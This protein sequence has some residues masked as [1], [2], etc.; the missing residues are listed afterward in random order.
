M[1]EYFGMREYTAET[2]DAE[3]WVHTGDLGLVRPD[4]YVQ[5]TGR[6]KDMIIRG[7]ENIY[8]R[9]IEDQL[10]GHPAVEQAAVFGVPDAQ[11]GEQVVAAIVP[12][13]GQ[14]LD[15]DALT[16][17]LTERV[18]KYKLPR[19]WVAVQE[20]PLNTSGKVQKFV[21]Q[22]EYPQLLE[23]GRVVVLR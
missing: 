16:E 21:L 4:D 15:A 23:S 12:K 1:A 10:V 19:R 14:M 20:L 3:G 17:F 13:P 11:W 7:G 8:P 6:L 5:I 22:N 18:A 9:E 2:L